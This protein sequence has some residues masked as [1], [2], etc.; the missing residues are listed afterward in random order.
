VKIL[1]NKKTDMQIA[2]D[3]FKKF[4]TINKTIKRHNPTAIY[5]EVLL[6]IKVVVGNYCRDKFT[7]SFFDNEGGYPTCDL[8]L[9]DLSYDKEGRC[10]KPK[11]C[12]EL[13]SI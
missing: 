12:L 6:P 11:K 8:N 2:S 13:K 7:C 3:L 5:K 1:E 4:P 10:P 9:G